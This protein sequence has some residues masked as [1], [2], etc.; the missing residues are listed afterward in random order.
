MVLIDQWCSRDQQGGKRLEERN[1]IENE[2][3]VKKGR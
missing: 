2:E 3:G 1:R